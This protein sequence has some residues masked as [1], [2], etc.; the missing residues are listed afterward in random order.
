MANL[1][2]KR[3]MELIGELANIF[4]EL[5]WLVAIPTAEDDTCSGLIVGEQSFVLDVTKAFYGEDA[6]I[7][8]PNSE[9]PEKSEEINLKLTD[10]KKV[11]H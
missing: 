5:E 7:L 8:I 11:V 9:N 6:E 10:G 2:K 1:S 4:E 3:Q